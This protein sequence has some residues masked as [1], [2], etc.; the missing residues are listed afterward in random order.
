MKIGWVMLG[1]TVLLYILTAFFNPSLVLSALDKSFEIIKSIAPIIIVVLVLM[2][3]FTTLVK[4]KKMIKH[5]GE[6]SGIKGWLISIFGGVLSHGSTYIWYPILSQMRAEGAR[7]G[8]IVAFFY[9][10]AIKLP[11]LP[12]M[13]AYFGLWFTLVLSIYILVGAFFQGVI[14]DKI[15]K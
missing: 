10:R 8:L 15:K 14:A 4:P 7:E 2:A 5:I 11:W 1:I 3:A 9:A 13:V 12:V 6:D